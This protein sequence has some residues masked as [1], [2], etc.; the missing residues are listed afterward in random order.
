MSEALETISNPMGGGSGPQSAMV[1]ATASREAQ[2]VQAMM[3]IAKRFPRD[4]RQA[5]DRILAA[6]TRPTL[7]E[8]AMYTYNRGGT[9]VTGPSIRLAECIAQQWGNIEYGI[10][11]LEQRDGE[12]TVEAFAWDTE[13]NTRQVKV[14]QVKHER[15]TKRGSYKL[16]DPRDV[17]EMVANQ[18]AR[19]LRACI[20]GIVPGDVV[21]AAVGQCEVTM[22]TREKVTPERIATM[23]EVFGKWGVTK[24]QIEKRIQRR[25]DAMT[26]GLLVQL[27]K[28]AN[29]LRDGMSAPADWFEM[30]TTETP[31]APAA[32]P[33]RAAAKL[34]AK[35][36]AEPA[37]AEPAAD[38]K[39]KSNAEPYKLESA[40]S[41]IDSTGTPRGVV[42]GWLVAKGHLP[43][44]KG[45]ESLNQE[46]IALLVENKLDVARAASE[47]FD[48]QQAKG[49]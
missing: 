12:S 7:A 18:G 33:S 17:Y 5:M 34:A 47:W 13:T 25:L 44:G 45:L 3:V 35:K 22:T 8:S 20:L 31:G 48:G 43:Q 10:R 2:E 27:G 28:I 41:A 24:E 38:P 49:E 30:P 14:F 46:G 9:D 15:H 16:D 23:L 40:L 36:A 29:S 39:P 42:V 19:R 1:T 21:D 32:T 11:E 6:C 26:P 37:P 4:Q